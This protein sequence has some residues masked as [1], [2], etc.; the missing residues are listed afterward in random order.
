MDPATIASIAAAI[1]GIGGG[2]KNLFGGGAGDI[3][4]QYQSLLQIPQIREMLDLQAGQARN[5]APLQE[6]LVRMSMNLLPKSA[7]S[8]YGWYDT[9]ASAAGIE[10][11]RSAGSNSRVGTAVR[12]QSV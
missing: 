1:F 4:K 12:R 6:A 9:P 2:I 8:G 10:G 5:Q 11:S 7:R 3:G